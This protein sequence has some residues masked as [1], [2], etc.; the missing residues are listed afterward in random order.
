MTTP[1]TDPAT[2][3]PLPGGYRRAVTVFDKVLATVPAGAWTRGSACRGWSAADVVGHCVWAQQ[4]LRHGALGTRYPDRAGGP[5]APHPAV[6][7]GQDPVEAWRVTRDD[8]L[9]ALTP[10][11]LTREFDTPFRRI[12]VSECCEMLVMDLLAHAWDIASPLG[13]P[14]PADDDLAADALA[15]SL[16]NVTV[17]PAG[18]LDPELPAS[19]GAD[20]LT[21]LLAF[22]GRDTT[23]L[24]PPPA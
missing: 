10:A 12:S 2:V 1:P 15:W 24:T 22:L 8:T 18:T 17:R 20:P 4:M 21:R 19:P 5:G 9:A 14:V 6:L 11:A 23:K 3:T 16:T 13:L 7:C